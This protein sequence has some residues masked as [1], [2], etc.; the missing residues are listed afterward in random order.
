[1]PADHACAVTPIG[2]QL[3]AMMPLVELASRLS[4]ARRSRCALRISEA[5]GFY[6][7]GDIKSADKWPDSSIVIAN[8]AD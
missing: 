7:R 5:T 1:M 6:Q 2:W 4:T 8:A 3:F